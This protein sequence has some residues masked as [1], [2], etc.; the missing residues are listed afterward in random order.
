MLLIFSHGKDNTKLINF[1]HIS[2]INEELIED[3]QEKENIST[4]DLIF[5]VLDTTTY[6]SDYSEGRQLGQVDGMI[7]EISSFFSF[8]S[9]LILL[10][11]LIGGPG[12][13]TL[14]ILWVLGFWSN[15]K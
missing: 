8:I 6:N 10:I 2:G 3:Q 9:Y 5:S 14:G 1:S 4:E 12:G 15:M 7:R 11:T 13:I